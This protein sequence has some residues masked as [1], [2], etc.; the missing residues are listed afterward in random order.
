MD[1]WL[2]RLESHYRSAN[3]SPPPILILH[4][5]DELVW[6]SL[7]HT[8][9]K[10]PDRSIEWILNK[11]R[12]QKGWNIQVIN[13]GA[14]VIPK[15]QNNARGL[16]VDQHFRSTC[17]GTQ[18]IA[19]VIAH[20]FY[21]DLA[22]CHHETIVSSVDSWM[23]EL[24]PT[25]RGPNMIPP[26]SYTRNTTLPLADLLFRHDVRMRS[27]THYWKPQDG[28][29]STPLK[30]PNLDNAKRFLEVMP[31]PT[32]PTSLT[33]TTA[34]QVATTM[35]YEHLS[36]R[37]PLCAKLTDNHNYDYLNLTI[38]EPMLEWLGVAYRGG[39]VQA[40]INGEPLSLEHDGKIVSGGL[41]GIRD[42]VHVGHVVPH[43]PTYNISFCSRRI[44]KKGKSDVW[45]HQLVGVLL[46]APV[47]SSMDTVQ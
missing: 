46:P 22:G 35:G 21:Q 24:G 2:S 4:L 19:H 40:S 18:F 8:Q 15:A 12:D 42:W 31:M 10:K 32:L 28:M 1:F 5:W 13:V 43:A 36:Y 17:R 6:A 26:E 29:S 27:L 45:L 11:Y 34:G 33:A 14:A 20:A 38:A 3:R 44:D 7:K 9:V 47:P 37:L 23:T 25:H 16:L 39:L 41:E 30:I